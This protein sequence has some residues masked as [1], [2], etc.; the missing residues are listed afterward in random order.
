MKRILIAGI[1]NI[2]FGDD[3][4]G[5]E[6]VREL[7][8]HTLPPEVRVIDFGIRGYDLAYALADGYD[9]AILVDATPRGQPPGTLYLIEPDIANLAPM[10]C[11]SVDPHSLGPIR[12]LQMA[13][14]LGGHPAQIFLI[15]CEPA[16]LS[17]ADGHMGLSDAVQAAVPK[18]V[19]MIQ[20]LL[21]NLVH[22]ETTVVAGNVPA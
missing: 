8:H 7:P 12:V 18:A 1:G 6:V 16:D 14:S 13:E 9:A 2:F 20:S 5:V 22:S 11:T 21:Q 3:A 19:E 10:E 15:G 4:F 17:S